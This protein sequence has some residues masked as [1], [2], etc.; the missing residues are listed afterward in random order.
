MSEW[1][2]AIMSKLSMLLSSMQPQIMAAQQAT[3]GDGKKK[4]AI[5]IGI[6]VVF[7]IVYIFASKGIKKKM[8]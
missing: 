4:L 2:G 6:A 7:V 1:K 3:E 5:L 8:K